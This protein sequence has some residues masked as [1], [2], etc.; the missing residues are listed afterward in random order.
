MYGTISPRGPPPPPHL[1]FPSPPPLPRPTTCLLIPPTPTPS[2]FPLFFHFRRPPTSR[3]HPP[4]GERALRCSR[5]TAT[6][7]VFVKY[8]DCRV[9]AAFMSHPRGRRMAPRCSCSSSTLWSLSLTLC[10]DPQP[11]KVE[12]LEQV[13]HQIQRFHQY[14]QPDHECVT[15][16]KL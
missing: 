14:L 9:A 13:Y 4:P 6:N 16:R 12:L 15:Q 3:H 5:H 7:T 2:L 1:P 11:R 8:H 10:I